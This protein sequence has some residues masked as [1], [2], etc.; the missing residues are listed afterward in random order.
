MILLS[1]SEDP[2]LIAWIHSLFSTFYALICLKT[3]FHMARLIYSYQVKKK[4]W[5]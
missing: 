5:K 2:D 1:D 3:P 4:N